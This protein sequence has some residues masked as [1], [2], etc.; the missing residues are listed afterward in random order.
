M[1]P[2]IQK[3]VII[4]P[5]TKAKAKAKAKSPTKTPSKKRVSR[6]KPETEYEKCRKII[7]NRYMKL[8]ERG[9]L[10]IRGNKVNS[11]KQAIAIALQIAAKSCESKMNRDDIQELKDK[12]NR[13][14][15][16][17][18]QDRPLRY[19]DI[20]RIEKLNAYYKKRGLKASSKKL[21]TF[22]RN[23][24]Q[25]ASKTKKIPI[26]HQKTLIKLADA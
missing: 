10:K 26:H 19:S 21:I 25:A 11:P 20:L 8:Y 13:L 5:K 4:R 12:V 6:K 14:F 22:A 24:L 16:P 23:Y 7:I 3:K 9:V 17:E 2:S 1:P 15:T 18:F